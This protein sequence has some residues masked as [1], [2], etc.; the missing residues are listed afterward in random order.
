MTLCAKLPRSLPVLLLVAGSLCA[1][2]GG[3]S[4]GS[5]A[6]T[7]GVSSTATSTSSSGPSLVTS[8][9][10]SAIPSALAPP[11][12]SLFDDPSY[13]PSGP[14]AASWYGRLDDPA[15]LTN[16]AAQELALEMAGNGLDAKLLE[17]HFARGG[18]LAIFVS[19]AGHERDTP[20]RRSGWMAP[21]ALHV[22]A[23]LGI[24]AIQVDYHDWA[25]GNDA[26]ALATYPV[27]FRTGVSRTH[28]LIEK[29]RSAGVGEV[30]LYGHSKG[31]DVVQEVTWSHA[32]D[33]L[34]V[35]SVVFGIPL[36]SAANPGSD[37]R[38]GYG[39][40]F[41]YGA[42]GNRDYQGKLVVFIRYSDRSSRGEMLPANTFPGPGHEYKHVLGT[43]GFPERLDEVRFQEPSGFADRAAGQTYDY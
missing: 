7:A 21:Y 14:D 34:L 17:E 35:Q 30:R 24:P 10:T 39:G 5:A 25:A 28:A 18:A 15:T 23:S 40:L 1:C 2:S 32:G 29:A 11:L 36:W 20:T 9:T 41:R 33:P 22:Q 16:E 13:V 37:P 12:A 26:R 8:S 31:G 27:S 38:Y 6:A 42:H 19:G 3:S 43:P 4:S